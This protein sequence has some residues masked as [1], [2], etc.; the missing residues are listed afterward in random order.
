[1]VLKSLA[2]QGDG[3]CRNTQKLVHALSLSVSIGEVSLE[4]PAVITS[5]IGQSVA[6]DGGKGEAGDRFAD[7]HKRYQGRS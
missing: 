1:M 3:R 7:D 5:P 4:M 6:Q 2:A